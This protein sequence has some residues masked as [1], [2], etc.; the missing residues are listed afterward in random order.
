MKPFLRTR[1]NGR[2]LYFRV[3]EPTGHYRRVNG[4]WFRECVIELP[5]GL[6]R[7]AAVREALVAA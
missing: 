7:R 3:V 5:D 1:H 4:E 6:R 2:V